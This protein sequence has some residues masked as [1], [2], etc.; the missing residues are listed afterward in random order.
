[1]IKVKYF[2]PRIDEKSLMTSYDYEYLARVRELFGITDFWAT[3]S[4][5]FNDQTEQEDRQFLLDRL[6]NFKKL[7]IR[8]HAYIQGPN[9]VYD[10]FPGKDWWARDERGRLIPYYRGR[11]MCSIHSEAYVAY[12]L[13]KIQSM[14]N[15]GFDGIYVDNIQHGQ[16]GVPNMPGKLPFVFAGDYSHHARAEF[17]ALT[18]RDIPHDFERDP[19]L[20]EAY[21]NFRVEANTR[22]IGR[23]ADAVHKGGMEF[24]T[25]FYDP[26]FDP[27]YIYAIDL[28]KKTALQDYILFE[29][30]ALPSS[31]GKISNHY[32]EQLID[33]R[34][35]TKPVFVVSY[36]NGV[37]MAPQFEQED[38]DNVFSEAAVSNFRLC[39]KGSEFTTKNVW[40]NLY[41]EDYAP[42]RCDKVLPR[43]AKE[44]GFTALFLA[45]KIPPFRW[46]LK[47]YYNPLY[48]IAFEWRI[49][50][51]LVKVV[52]DTTLK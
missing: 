22:F 33:Q 28:D 17:R 14:T 50:F 43:V 13:A 29:N 19:E 18:G 37:G 48:R 34:Q 12:V 2:N 49:A 45:L 52:Y 7:G 26:K 9:L 31:D 3:Y 44:P 6:E 16:L 40:H 24:G 20:T 47:R 46:T 39:L 5:G 36:R 8:V 11:R 25:N 35:I 51:F 10:Q 38:I 30:H 27:K 41:L 23:L 15:K 21:L 4:W 1:M 42:P 32:I